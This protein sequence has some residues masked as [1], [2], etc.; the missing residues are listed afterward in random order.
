MTSTPE[1]LPTDETN[2]EKSQPAESAPESDDIVD[3]AEIIQKLED[4][5][6]FSLECEKKDLKP[7]VS[8]VDVHKQL[9]Q[10]QKDINLFQENYRA[11]LAMVGL[12]PEEVRPTPEDIENLDPKQKKIFDRMQALQSTCETSRERLYQSM[13]ADKETLNE[14]KSELKDKGKEKIRRKGKF[15]GLGGKQGWLPT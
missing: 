11:H 4:L 8:F 3:V 2:L 1:D 5:V 6:K 10:I 13:Q 9:L 12:T 15:K 14:V 7:D